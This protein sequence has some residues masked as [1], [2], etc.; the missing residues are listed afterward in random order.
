M[1][2][3]LL[4]DNKTIR[5]PWGILRELERQGSYIVKEITVPPRK[6]CSLHVHQNHDEHWLIVSGT[7]QAVIGDKTVAIE[8]NTYV[9]LPRKLPH[10]VINSGSE[11]LCYIEIVYG[12]GVAEDDLE[13]LDCTY[14][15]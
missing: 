2:K 6:Q 14:D 1:R 9:S 4:Q 5:R 11:P 13:K 3:Q 8:P 15:F 12:E 7:G 10:R